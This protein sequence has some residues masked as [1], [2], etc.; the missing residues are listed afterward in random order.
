M[1]IKINLLLNQIKSKNKNNKKTKIENKIKKQID[2]E[3][4][5]HLF[6]NKKQ[7]SIYRNSNYHQPSTRSN[8]RGQALSQSLEKASKIV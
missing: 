4:I 2:N 7:S 5:F 8:W 1:K 3:I 6:Q